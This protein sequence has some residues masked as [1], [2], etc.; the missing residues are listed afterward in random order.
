[1]KLT[2]RR[3]LIGMPSQDLLRRNLAA[4]PAN[5]AQILDD[6]LGHKGYRE[7]SKRVPSGRDR[8]DFEWLM[9]PFQYARQVISIDQ[10]LSFADYLNASPIWQ[11]AAPNFLDSAAATQVMKPMLERC[12]N[13]RTQELANRLNA[14]GLLSASF[15]ALGYSADVV[16][17][18]WGISLR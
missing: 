8:F 10:Y 1:M 9:N 6:D 11:Y 4:N 16:L 18:E 3:F 12:P 2:D 7:L 17:R 5:F 15:D 13:D 14:N